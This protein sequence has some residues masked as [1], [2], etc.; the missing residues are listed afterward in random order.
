MKKISR[1]AE[2][3]KSRGLTQERLAEMAG[4]H[5]VLIARYE[6]GITKPSVDSLVKIAGALHVTVDDL[7][8]KAG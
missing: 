4:L 8:E 7:I 3:R 6:A 2:F 5:R 1:I